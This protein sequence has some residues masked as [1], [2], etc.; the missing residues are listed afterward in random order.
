MTTQM[1]IR[2]DTEQ[3]QRLDRLARREGLSTSQAVRGL[4]DAY[5]AERDIEACVD[6]LWDRIGGS[7][8]RRGVKPADVDK[9]ITEV[10]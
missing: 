10:R 5:I 4:I 8:L 6:E 7:L 1:I 9:A 2:M 3:K